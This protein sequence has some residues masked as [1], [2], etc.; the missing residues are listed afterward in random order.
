MNTDTQMNRASTASVLDR[1]LRIL[2]LEDD[3]NDRRVVQEWLR[4]QN[5]AAEFTDADNEA[6]F[7]KAIEEQS[8]DIILSDKSLPGFDGLAALRLVREK[9]PH[10]PFLFVTGS[11]GEEAAIE[12][13]K[14][15]A[16]DYVLKDRLSRLIPAVQRAVHESEQEEKNRNIEE[17]NR[18]QAALLDKAQDAIMVKDGADQILFWNKSAE[19]IYGWTASEMLGRKEAEL[20]TKD[21]AKYEEARQILLE[22]G[23]W[24]GELAKRNRGGNELIVESHWTLVP[25]D[26]ENPESVFIIDTDITEKK[27][28]EA[29]FLRSQRMD[30]IGALAGGIAHDLNNALAPVI[31][32]VELLRDRKDDSDREKFLDI[33]Q[34]NAQRASALVKQILSFARGSGGES[35]P[36]KLKHLL[37]ETGEMIQETFPKSIVFHAIKFPGKELWT[38]HGDPTELHQVLLNLCVNARDAMPHGGRLT[39][40]AQNIMLDEET[41]LATGAT[42][43]P[44]VMVSVADT[45][46]GIPPQV[47][48]R[49]FEPFFTTKQGDRGTGL[50]LATVAWIVKRHGG[51]IDIRTEPG[52]GTEFH[53]YL[54]AIDSVETKE[55]KPKEAGLPTGHGE[56]ILVIDD[57]ATLLELTKTTLESFGYRV[58]TAQN[59]LQGIAQFREN[60]QDIKLIVTDTDMPYM[61]GIGTIRAIRELQP[62]LPVI[63]ASGTEHDTEHLRRMGLG[64]LNSLGKPYNLDQLLLAVALGLQH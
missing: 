34:A 18:Q 57:E 19:R 2:H 1:A 32:G 31:M 36:V 46:T 40:S 9:F 13:M 16:T 5:I 54:P 49:I 38:I 17:K 4:G 8:F 48:P 44:Y 3:P 23:N 59:G 50:G 42:P 47:L 35:G 37:G 63:I 22:E 28:L 64:H 58:V 51:F 62:D 53:V 30:S 7:V 12:T 25:G 20:L 60:Q 11:M 27:A 10:I 45:G 21:A 29:K 55:T 52:K 41:A 39:L 15:G 6:D 26:L 24:T 56:L 33:I 43:G 14:D 61:D